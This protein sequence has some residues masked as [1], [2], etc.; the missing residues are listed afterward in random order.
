MKLGIIVD[1][2]CGLTQKEAEQRNWKFV[3]LIVTINKKDYRDGIDID[4]QKFYEMVNIDMDI[5]TGNTPPAEM[6][7]ALEEATANFDYVIVYPLSQPLSSQTDFFMKNAEKFNN[8]FVV[9]SKSVGFA[10]VNDCEILEKMAQQNYSW[11]QIKN[12][13]L[14][15]TNAFYG[16]IAPKTMKWLVKGARVSGTTASMAKLAKI[17]PIIQ[18]FQGKLIR[19]DRSHFFGKTVE[20]MA[21]ILSREYK[22]SEYYFTIYHGDNKNINEIAKNVE[23]YIP[24]SQICFFPPSIGS[25][26]GPG[27][28]A[29]AVHLKN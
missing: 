22:S 17:V 10:I 29:I 6:S 13:A 14:E 21:R 19:R 4:A 27:V 18:I 23:Q 20:K 25:H 8:V 28:V 12:H 26:V 11:D 9:P 16:L 24:I 2:S 1:S 5:T 15:L 7:K 3:P